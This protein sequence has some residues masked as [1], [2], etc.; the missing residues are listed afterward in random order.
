MTS[1]KDFFHPYENAEVLSKHFQNNNQGSFTYHQLRIVADMFRAI[2]GL[3][4][5]DRSLDFFLTLPKQEV[6]TRAEQVIKL[7]K[8]LLTIKGNSIDLSSA[9]AIW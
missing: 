3:K 8:L 1:Q 2:G 5:Q 6:I 4:A 9:S 7:N